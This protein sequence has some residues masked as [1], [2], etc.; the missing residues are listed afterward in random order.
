[1]GAMSTSVLAP[2]GSLYKRQPGV[3][4]NVVVVAN[5]AQTLVVGVAFLK[6]RHQSPVTIPTAGVQQVT[7]SW[8]EW[9]VATV[10]L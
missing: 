7:G 8:L 9:W 6:P 5:G 1:M 3:N 10:V 2:G 4:D